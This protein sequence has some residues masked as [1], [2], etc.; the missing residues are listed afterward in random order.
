MEDFKYDS[1]DSKICVMCGAPVQGDALFCRD[2]SQEMDGRPGRRGARE[3]G[4][5]PVSYGGGSYFFKD[6]LDGVSKNINLHYFAVIILM[7]F[8]PFLILIEFTLASY[9]AALTFACA[10]FIIAVVIAFAELRQK[11]VDFGSW[12]FLR[13]ALVLILSVLCVALGAVYVSGAV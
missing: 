1:P 9:A 10:A 11:P 13:V 12:A 2:C 5:R 3:S 7:A 8:A 6:F 4:S